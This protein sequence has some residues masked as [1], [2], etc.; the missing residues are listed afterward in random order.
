MGFQP[1]TVSSVGFKKLVKMGEDRPMTFGV[2]LGSQ[3]HVWRFCTLGTI[4]DCQGSSWIAGERDL[5]VSLYGTCFFGCHIRWYTELGCSDAG[6]PYTVTDSP[7]Q[8]MS[9][10]STIQFHTPFRGKET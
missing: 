10:E 9:I 8:P 1:S 6:S 7:Y 4:E 5:L 2:Y 3:V